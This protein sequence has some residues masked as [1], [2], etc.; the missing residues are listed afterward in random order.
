MTDL[1]IYSYLL[2]EFK[3]SPRHQVQLFYW[4]FYSYFF[5]SESIYLLRA[6]HAE[7]VAR[8]SLLCVLVCLFVC[9]CLF[10]NWG[11]PYVTLFRHFPQGTTTKHQWYVMK[12]HH[13]EV[14]SKVKY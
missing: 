12:T 7:K 8:I 2:Y 5:S 10:L 11:R 1:L 14:I 6:K 3:V 13:Y 4:Q 9:F